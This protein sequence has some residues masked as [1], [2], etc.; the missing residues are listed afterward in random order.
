VNNVH[1][2]GAKVTGVAIPDAIQPAITYAI[3][4]VKATQ[5]RSAAQA[6]VQSAISGKVQEALQAQGFVAP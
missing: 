6:F 4:V 1:T 3:A 5:K 2:A